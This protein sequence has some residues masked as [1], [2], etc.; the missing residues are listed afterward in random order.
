MPTLLAFKET[1]LPAQLQ[2]NALYFV[3]PPA[4]PGYVEIYVTDSAGDAVRRVIDQATIQGMI[5]AAIAGGTGGGV[6]VDDIAARN[7]LEATNALQVLVIDASAD[8]TVTT[9]AATYVW[10]ETSN[11]WI[12]ISEAESMD[13]SLS[14]VALSGRPSSTPANIDAAVTSRHTHTNATQLGQIGEDGDQNLTY[15]GARPGVAW[16][17]TGW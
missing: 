10:R 14:W 16:N 13:L 5:D 1:A 11:A 8:P 9:G 7:A 15:R 17:S 4:R 2:A 6:I 12:K 3:A